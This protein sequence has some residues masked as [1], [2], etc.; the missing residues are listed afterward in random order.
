MLPIKRTTS[1][2][3]LVVHLNPTLNFETH[4]NKTYKKAAGRVNLLLKIRSF[5]TCAAAESIYRAMIMPVF[6][7]CH[8]TTLRNSNTRKR[9]ICNIENRGL[10]SVTSG[11]GIMNIRI[12]SI[13]GY[14]TRKLCLYVLDCLL[15]NVCTPFKKYFSRTNHNLTQG[16]D[17]H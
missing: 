10:N 16:T 14:L 8:L 11:L 3:Y 6:T 13:D 1:Y 5:I 4:F 17:F 12:P 15:G 7:Y 9:Q 2:K